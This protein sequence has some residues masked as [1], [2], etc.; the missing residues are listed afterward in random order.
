MKDG[1]ITNN[2]KR[3]KR[4]ISKVVSDISNYMDATRK[5][6]SIFWYVLKRLLRIAEWDEIVTN[7]EVN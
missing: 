1:F 3:R 4:A 7:A 6:I 2:L 5:I